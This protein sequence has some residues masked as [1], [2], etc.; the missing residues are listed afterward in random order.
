MYVYSR[1]GPQTAPA[2]RPSLIYCG[3]SYLLHGEKV[4]F[5]KSSVQ[6]K[7]T[8]VL[9][10]FFD[11]EDGGDT[12]FRNVDVLNPEDCALYSHIC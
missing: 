6:Y 4:D 12:S 10:S 3:V 1:G 7:S 11:H 2:P 5:E 9:G 8:D